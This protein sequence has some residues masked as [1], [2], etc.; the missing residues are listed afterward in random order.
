MSALTETSAWKALVSHSQEGK[1]PHLR[2]LLQ[3]IERCNSLI[4]STLD[5]TLDLS[6]QRATKETLPLLLG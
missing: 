5:I 4:R 3:D 1:I 6:R 2:L